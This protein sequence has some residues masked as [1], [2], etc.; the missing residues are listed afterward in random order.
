MAVPFALILMKYREVLRVL[1]ILSRLFA[2]KPRD[3]RE[4]NRGKGVHR[5]FLFEENMDLMPGEVV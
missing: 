5:G 1:S 2:Q 4:E 3:K